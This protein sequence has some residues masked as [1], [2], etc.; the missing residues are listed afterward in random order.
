MYGTDQ[1]T[2][3]YYSGSDPEFTHYVE[4]CECGERL[5]PD[6]EDCHYDEITERFYCD[7]CWKEHLKEEKEEEEDA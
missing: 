1:L 5:D 4:C 7:D 3:L 6:D 2:E